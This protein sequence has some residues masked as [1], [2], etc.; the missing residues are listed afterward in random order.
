MSAEFIDWYDRQHELREGDIFRLRSGEVVKL[1]R[2][3]PGDGTDWYAADW[4][5]GSWA[6]M[7]ARHHPGDF[8]EKL[9]DEWSGEDAAV[10]Q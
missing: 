3:V 8:A 6:Y 7:D 1:D 10:P 2:R 5:A 4:W 9:P